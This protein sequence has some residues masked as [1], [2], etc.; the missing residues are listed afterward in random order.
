MQHEPLSILFVDDETSLQELMRM[1]IPHM[2]H[3]V[4]V[5]PDGLTAI[6]AM[7]KDTFDCMIVD[8][9]MPGMNGLQ[10]I[11]RASKMSPTM[12]CVV[13][14][15]KQSLESAVF[16]LKY[17]VIDYI[18]KPCK[19]SEMNELFERVR[20]RRGLKLHT[21]ALQKAQQPQN[22]RTVLIGQSEE[23]K[24][25]ANLV[26]KVAKTNSSVLIRGETGCGKELVARSVHEHSLRAN[27]AFV[28]VNCGALPEHLIESELFGHKKGAFTGAD[29]QR[30]GLFHEAD[31]GTIFLDEIG[32]LPLPM[33]AKLL[34]V[35]ES[36]DIR[37]VGDNEVHH[38]DVRVVCATHRNLEQMVEEQTFR[39]DLMFR[40]NT[41]EI[42]VPSLRERADD[43][44]LLARH[45]Y[46]R[47][48][49]EH[50]SIAELF[51]EETIA[52]FKQHPWP[53]NVRELANVVEY[54]TILCDKPPIGLKHLPKHFCD[55]R[56]KREVRASMPALTL[57]D[58]EVLAVQ[59]AIDRHNG[60]KPAAAEELG[61]SLKT[62]YNKLN[63]AEP[64]RRAAV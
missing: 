25:I 17:G 22:S 36:G 51:D 13:L 16:A 58:M 26:S 50:D 2:G 30:D 35:L 55:K 45:L 39:E 59:E 57:R 40:V 49:P 64:G 37:R 60:N 12:D 21:L 23:M 38:V 41:F 33:Q 29:S 14:T 47:H 7:E 9:D 62:L 56:M 43:V 44:M 28:A 52:A 34:R 27:R 63:Q 48:H 31:G 61:I 11:E 54:A 15:G 18:G 24:T 6:A 1:E 8:L 4:T 5:C 42:H 32:E 19:L 20:A 3:R 53:G 10:V 46:L